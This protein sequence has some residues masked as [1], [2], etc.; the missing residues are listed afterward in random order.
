MMKQTIAANPENGV[1]EF[2]QATWSRTSWNSY[3]TA[4]KGDGM[5]SGSNA[6]AERVQDVRREVERKREVDRKDKVKA[7]QQGD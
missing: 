4:D 3:S 5:K 1:V 6:E 7:E 2:Q